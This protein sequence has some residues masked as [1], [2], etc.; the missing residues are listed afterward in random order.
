MINFKKATGKDGLLANHDTLSYHTNAVA[1]GSA[2]IHSVESPKSN[3]EYMVNDTNQQM[4]DE[5]IHILSCIVDAVLFLGKQN[6]A[7]RGHRDDRTSTD[8]NKGNFWAIL[9]L[10]SKSDKILKKHLETAKKNAVYTSKTVQNELITIIGEQIRKTITSALDGENPFFSIIADEVTDHYKNEEVLSVCLRILDDDAIKEVFIDFVS[11]ERTRGVDIAAAILATLEKRSINVSMARGQSYD[12]ASCMSSEKVGV[13]KLIRDQAPLAIYTH[14]RS[15]VLNLSIAS[16]CKLPP[17]RNMMDTISE[18]FLFFDNSPKR[19]RYFELILDSSDHS[20]SR[21]KRLKGFC[22]TRW[23]ERHTC[24]ETF[25]ELSE[26]VTNTLEGMVNTNRLD[27]WQFDKDTRIKAQGLLHA[28][29]NSSTLVAFIVA[30]NVLDIIKPVTVKLQKADKDVYEAYNLIDAVKVELQHLRNE[31]DNRFDGTIFADVSALAEKLGATITI[32]RTVGRQRHRAGAGVNANT[33]PAEYYKINIC[34][35]F[36][37]HIITEMETRFKAKDQLL[38]SPLFKLIPR[39]L[40][41][42]DSIQQISDKLLFW[43]SDLPTPLSL[44]N[45]IRRWSLK[46]NTTANVPSTTFLETLKVTDGDEFPNIKI[47]LKIACV[48]PIGSASAERSFSAYRRCNTYLRSTMGE[49]RRSDLCLMH[50]HHSLTSAINVQDIVK[51]YI[52]RNKRRLFQSSVL[53][54]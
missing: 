15:H 3:V 32:P 49:E 33:E 8:S 1:K 44:V 40:Q 16:S 54:F 30:K 5:N 20:D 51:T 42:G 25:L 21:K 17:I 37:D 14:C 4:F 23:V 35:P 7:L 43:E 53:K 36:L 11:M 46:W 22:K 52:N 45:E 19:Q 29:S 9:E 27:E 48:L 41:E 26:N 10:I 39:N 12:G 18:T 24:F 2:L 38:A 34:I 13:Q 28:L 47:L 6:L 50:I 31:I